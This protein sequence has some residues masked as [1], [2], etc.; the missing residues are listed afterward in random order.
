VAGPVRRDPRRRGLLS[1]SGRLRIELGAEPSLSLPTWQGRKSETPGHE[2]QPLRCPEPAGTHLLVLVYSDHGALDEHARQVL[3]AAALIATPDMGVVAAV[4]G[5]LTED[6]ARLAAWGAD[7]IV[8]LPDC[9]SERWQPEYTLARIHALRER[10]RPRHV[11][12][13]ERSSGEADLGR[14]LAAAAGLSIATHVSEIDA[15]H[16]A[17]VRSGSGRLSH[18]MPTDVIL[19]LPDAVD[20]RLP[21]AGRG[22]RIELPPSPAAPS[23]Y[24]DAGLRRLDSAELALEQAD[25]I[26][27]AGNGVTDVA[28]FEQLA[29]ALG[30]ATGASRVAVDDGRFPRDKQIGATG[31]SVSANAY[32]AF[33]ISG[34]IQHL[35]GIRDCRHVIAVNIDA[36]APLIARANLSIIHD[37]QTLM[38]ALLEL[39]QRARAAASASGRAA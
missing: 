2:P 1:A 35:Q 10:F 14:R 12:L 39:V 15:T 23:H 16:V 9:P 4:L 38:Q 20:P 31:R 36:T 24:R 34:A 11:L 5:D 8:T 25:L 6:S 13:P 18:R 7:L 33:G 17:S 21:F 3:A 29:R 28:L 27:A 22:E 30:A 32:L 19:L 37:A 26:L